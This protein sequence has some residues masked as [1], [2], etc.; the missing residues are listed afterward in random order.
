MAA[1]ACTM[2]LLATVTAGRPVEC[3][4]TGNAGGVQP[5][6][7]PT[8]TMAAAMVRHCVT[9]RVA[10]VPEIWSGHD[11]NH[12]H[13]VWVCER[14]SDDIGCLHGWSAFSNQHGRSQSMED[15]EC[16]VKVYRR[17]WW[18]AREPVSLLKPRLMGRRGGRVTVSTLGD[19][20]AWSARERM[21]SGSG[22]RGARGERGAQRRGVARWACGVARERHHSRTPI[23]MSR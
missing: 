13:L 22:G 18:C 17:A 3:G 12:E 4:M 7:S 23:Q 2:V 10:L 21:R 5:A 11:G 8:P 6:R 9:R 19:D 15:R 14:R 20:G 1:P 16:H